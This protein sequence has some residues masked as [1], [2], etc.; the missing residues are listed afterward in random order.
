MI[1]FI[2]PVCLVFPNTPTYTAQSQCLH[3]THLRLFLPGIGFTRDYRGKGYL[4]SRLRY[5][6]NTDACFPSTR[7]ITSGDICPN[8]GPD[9]GTTRGSLCSVCRKTVARNYRAINCDLCELWC[10][11]RC[12][13][14]KPQEYIKL[15]SVNH[16]SWTCPACSST[17]KSLPFANISNLAAELALDTSSDTSSDDTDSSSVDDNS[18]PPFVGDLIQKYSKKFKIAHINANSIA[19][20]KFHEIKLWLLKGTFGVLVTTET[21]LDHTFRDAQLTID[22][23]RFTCLDRSVHDGGVIIYWRSDLIF[24]YSKSRSIDLFST[25]SSLRIWLAVN[26]SR[27]DLRSTC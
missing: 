13:G 23:Y 26:A 7:L 22:G 5:Y 6:S 12:G 11:I 14:V 18:M 24:N 27:N 3:T 8:P 15:Q 20:F 10:H 9:H 19:G 2:L 4:S 25:Y 21:K 1:L 16:F 17:L